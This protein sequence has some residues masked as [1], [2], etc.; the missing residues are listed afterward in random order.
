VLLCPGIYVP[1][2]GLLPASPIMSM[3]IFLLLQAS[4]AEKHKN[5][6]IIT[7]SAAS[8]SVFENQFA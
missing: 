2:D 4:E 8:Y 5:L 6:K 1:D 3:L 7:A